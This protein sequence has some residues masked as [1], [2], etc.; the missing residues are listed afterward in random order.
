MTTGDAPVVE[1]PRT[2]PLTAQEDP[3][4]TRV[5]E[6]KG[7]RSLLDMP[8]AQHFAQRCCFCN[9][10]VRDPNAVKRRLS[11]AHV[12]QW[13]QVASRL[14]ARCAEIK[15]ILVRDGICPFPWCARVSYSRHFKQCNIVFQCALL[16]LL[17]EDGGGGS[18]GG[19]GLAAGSVSPAERNDEESQR[20]GTERRAAEQAAP[21]GQTRP[22]RRRAADQ[23]GQPQQRC[24][25]P[26]GSLPSA[27]RRT[28]Q[29]PTRQLTHIP[30]RT[31]RT[32]GHSQVTLRSW[33]I[34]AREEGPLPALRTVVFALLVS[35]M[36]PGPQCS[37]DSCGAAGDESQQAVR[38]P[39]MESQ[40]A[41][42]RTR[43]RPQRSQR[44][45][46]PAAPPE[47]GNVLQ[48]QHHNKMCANSRKNRRKTRKPCLWSK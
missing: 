37:E 18:V 12:D 7:W 46:D 43:S 33:T 15:H 13:K 28:Q 45:A 4:I 6:E 31:N 41:K 17:H 1:T 30:S 35:E 11:Q 16:G 22:E 42:T 10:W 38:L 20:I 34:V 39:K 2:T 9:R 26:G 47:A 23:S 14:E 44:G 19:R 40:G 8:L 29:S 32:R 36:N 3:E 27:G 24:L 25:D 48:G 5:L 21:A